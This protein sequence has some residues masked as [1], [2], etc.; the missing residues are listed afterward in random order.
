MKLSTLSWNSLLFGFIAITTISCLRL[1]YP[2]D[3]KLT[4]PLIASCTEEEGCEES[5][6]APSDCV[7]GEQIGT[8]EELG[9][10]GA[11]EACSV[12]L[13]CQ[14]NADCDSGLCFE[15]V[16]QASSCEDGV[17]NGDETDIDC[18]SNC[19]NQCG[20]NQGCRLASDCSTQ[21]GC[22]IENEEEIG[23]CQAPS[24]NDGIQNSS[25]VDV[26]CGGICP[27][28]CLLGNQCN[29]SEDCSEELTCVQ[30]MCSAIHCDDR[31]WN[32]SETD[33]DC[34]G[35]ACRAC[36]TLKKCEE[37]SDC[38]SENICIQS[39][40]SESLCVRESCTD[41]N[42]GEGETDIDCG[43]NDC[44]K[45]DVGGRCRIGDDC[46]SGICL[47]DNGRILDYENQGVDRGQCADHCGNMQQD[48]DETG[49]DCGG[50]SCSARCGIG[51]SC[52]NNSDCEMGL[53]CQ[54][55][56][57]SQGGCLPGG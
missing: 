3:E 1:S 15:G 5:G 33:I 41:G 49:T 21:G 37:S 16:C 12:T 44:L 51:D 7:D 48:G 13:S 10:A 34:G 25:E 28:R 55:S 40:E 47:D 54:R 6:T 42:K 2:V 22:M 36:G 23:L 35:P 32:E 45:C 26:D 17:K 57:D 50:S 52:M 9:C 8:E 4:D 11:C 43:G 46:V 24:C 30:S 39:T 31:E 19:P 18:G 14:R 38:T 29:E 56:G 53:I 27:R 20:L